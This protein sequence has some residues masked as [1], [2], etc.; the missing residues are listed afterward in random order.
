VLVPVLL[1]WTPIGLLA[2]L[3]SL[4]LSPVEAQGVRAPSTPAPIT[5]GCLSRLTAGAMPEGCPA[6]L[7]VYY[8][9]RMGMTTSDGGGSPYVDGRSHWR[10]RPWQ[11]P[12]NRPWH[13]PGQQAKGSSNNRFI[14]D[15]NC[16]YPGG[17]GQQESCIQK[18]LSRLSSR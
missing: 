6:D 5:H 8:T 3:M 11:R 1:R 16:P 17:S 13:R 14:C 15:S 2:L 18:C 4:A 10:P 9:E 7:G 12:W